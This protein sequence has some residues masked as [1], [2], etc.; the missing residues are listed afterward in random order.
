MF[1]SGGG[2]DVAVSFGFRFFTR[3]ITVSGPMVVFVSFTFFILI[4]EGDQGR[5]INRLDFG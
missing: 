4:W 2:W 1:P 5:K 3:C